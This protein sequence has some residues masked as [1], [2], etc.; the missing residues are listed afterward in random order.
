MSAR[1][2]SVLALA[3]LLAV[4][5]VAPG[6]SCDTGMIDVPDAQLPDAQVEPDA[7]LSFS[8]SA[9]ASPASTAT[10]PPYVICL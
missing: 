3:G 4:A 6:C 2:S 5:L 8:D 10:G 1:V 9:I 7:P